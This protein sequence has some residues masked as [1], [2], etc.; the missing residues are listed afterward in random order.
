MTVGPQGIETKSRMSIVSLWPRYPAFHMTAFMISK[1][2]QVLI[3]KDWSKIVKDH[4]R[5]V[6]GGSNQNRGP[7]LVHLHSQI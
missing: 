5:E 7:Q 1:S 3:D 2:E 6:L 4:S